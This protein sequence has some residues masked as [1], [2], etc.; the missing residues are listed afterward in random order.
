MNELPRNPCIALVTKVGESLP[1]LAP[2]KIIKQ[3]A[4]AAF[5]NDEQL[6]LASIVTPLRKIARLPIPQDSVSQQERVK[7]ENK[8]ADV[9]EHRLDWRRLVTYVPN[10]DLPVYNWFKFKEGF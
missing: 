1:P 2:K 5:L 4:A 6:D 7:L 10:K 8:Y 9:L 3:P